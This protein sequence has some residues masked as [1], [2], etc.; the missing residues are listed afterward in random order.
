MELDDGKIETGKLNPIFVGNF[1]M[2]S[3][4]D[5]PY[6]TNPLISCLVA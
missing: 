4:E 2:V 1:T 5:F 3:G 6:K